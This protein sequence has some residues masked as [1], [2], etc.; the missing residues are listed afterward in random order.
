MTPAKIEQ[1]D[2]YRAICQV[3]KAISKDGITKSKKNEQQG[4]K[5]RGIDDVYNSLSAIIAEAELCIL[6][7]MS[8]RT[9]E[10]RETQ[11]GGTLFY[12]TVRA[13]F[14]FVSARDG[15]C[16]TVTMYG[17]AMDSGDKATNKAMSAAY[18]YACMQVFC[19]PTEGMEDAD[20]TT[21]D[22]KGSAAAAKAVLDAK[23]TGKAPLV[24]P[25]DRTPPSAPKGA[26][27][28]FD[29][30]AMLEAMGKIK[31]RFEAIGAVDEYYHILKHDYMV[32]HTNKLPKNDGGATA[33]A[34]YKQLSLRV[35]DMEAW[36]KMYDFADWTE[37]TEA[38]GAMKSPIWV[39]GIKHTYNEGADKYEAAIG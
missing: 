28:P 1:P 31:A 29:F 22:V 23:L 7:R 37:A 18:K 39:N 16:H 11:K 15:S 12:V 14:D 32:D 25:E 2:V 33:T 5:F 24:A 9:K 13:E 8:D 34:C 26:K 36:R 4:Y 19:I 35:A 38:V 17:E 21:H 30:Y 27:K 10:E 3:S 6:P 20:A